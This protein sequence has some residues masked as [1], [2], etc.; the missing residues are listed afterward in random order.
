MDT[1]YYL[2]KA[3]ERPKYKVRLLFKAPMDK[4]KDKRALAIITN[5]E[6]TMKAPIINKALRLYSKT[7][8]TM[9]P[10]LTNY[11]NES[12]VSNS[13]EPLE[14]EA[15]EE[16]HGDLISKIEE[17]V[18]A[19]E[20]LNGIAETNENFKAIYD[21]YYR[22]L[23]PKMSLS[24]DGKEVTEEDINQA[25]ELV[26]FSL[27][28]LGQLGQSVTPQEE[29]RQIIIQLLEDNSTLDNA[30]D[31]SYLRDLFIEET[32]SSNST[33]K[34]RLKDLENSKSVIVKGKT[35]YLNTD[36]Q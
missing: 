13:L 10:D 28:N 4:K 17:E 31:K 5:P 1:K 21:D 15:L 3:I 22:L 24:G 9:K 12:L 23:N 33:F 2:T 35:V 34:R 8:A 36:K 20:V 19:E 26:N 14:V 27:D 16:L 6:D 32:D 18:L 7:L 11:V 25:I 29:H 30:M